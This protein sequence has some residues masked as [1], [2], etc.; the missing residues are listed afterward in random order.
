M[1]IVRST[2]RQLSTRYASILLTALV[3]DVTPAIA[4]Q[5]CETFMAATQVDQSDTIADIMSKIQPTEHRYVRDWIYGSSYLN[6]PPP[7]DSL[8]PPNDFSA[9]RYGFVFSHQCCVTPSEK[10][11]IK[12]VDLFANFGNSATCD[13]L[14]LR[15]L[16]AIANVRDQRDAEQRQRDD[17]NSKLR[18]IYQRSYKLNGSGE[19]VLDSS[20]YIDE[21]VDFEHRV[22]EGNDYTGEVKRDL[23]VSIASTLLRLSTAHREMAI[24]R[25]SDMATR[26]SHGAAMVALAANAAAIGEEVVIDTLR[27][28]PWRQSGLSNGDKTVSVRQR[29]LLAQHIAAL[30]SFRLQR[31]T[32]LWSAVHVLV[33]SSVPSG[34]P[35]RAEAY[36]L[37]KRFL[38]ATER[39]E[40]ARAFVAVAA[41]TAVVL[42]GLSSLAQV[43]GPN[44]V[45]RQAGYD[46]CT[47]LN[48]LGYF[49]D[50]VGNAAAFFGCS[51]W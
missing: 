32:F 39:A 25:L 42:Y 38:L 44:R 24:Q 36:Q 10:V 4:T 31:G 33:G 16:N 35:G 11:L 23:A 40:S 15:R 1:R 14:T 45:E 9:R 21:L 48:G 49:D 28:F 22:L 50:G 8:A 27:K 3:A 17:I 19:G 7:E 43:P 51:K 47:G 46:S 29:V 41:A 18:L 37:H 2:W 20:R 26:F 6:R 13:E 34:S 12:I 30:P 5:S